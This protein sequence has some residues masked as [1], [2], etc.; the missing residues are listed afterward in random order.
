MSCIL[1]HQSAAE[2]VLASYKVKGYD[3]VFFTSS[4]LLLRSLKASGATEP[5][6]YISAKH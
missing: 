3:K 6:F 1:C 5:T 2:W 4:R